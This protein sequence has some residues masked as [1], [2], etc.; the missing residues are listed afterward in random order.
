MQSMNQ[1]RIMPDSQTPIA[2]LIRKGTLRLREAAAGR[3]FYQTEPEQPPDGDMLQWYWNNFGRI[4][5]PDCAKLA[6]LNRGYVPRNPDSAGEF[7]LLASQ[8]VERLIRTMLFDKICPSDYVIFMAGGHGS[9]KSTFCDGIRNDLHHAWV[10]DSVPGSY[11]AT[12]E[13]L[14]HIYHRGAQAA[15]IQILRS[16]EEA[17]YNGVLKRSAHGW[18]CTPR[19]VFDR[20]H[21][22]VAHNISRL[23]KE[24]QRE[25]LQV[26]QIDNR[27]DA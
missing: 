5:N 15:I 9:G 14:N 8:L 21:A 4:I 6:F 17:W 7:H 22:A 27:T 12:R 20:T 25:G 13:T 11:Q 10:I 18:H 16:P 26:Y 23:Q 3:D 19:T 2:E 1:N 24:F